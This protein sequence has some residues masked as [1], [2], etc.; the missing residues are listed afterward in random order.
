MALSDSQI[1]ELQECL[2]A[3]R[4][5][6]KETQE[7]RFEEAEQILK[8]LQLRYQQVAQERALKKSA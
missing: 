2:T 5:G 8:E 4:D 3:V 7:G 6:I 1:K